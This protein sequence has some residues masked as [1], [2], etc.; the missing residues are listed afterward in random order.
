MTNG[1]GKRIFIIL[2]KFAT[3]EILREQP[4]THDT[5]I[6]FQTRRETTVET[7]ELSYQPVLSL[8]DGDLV[9]VQAV[10]PGTAH[11][12]RHGPISSPGRNR[13]MFH[14]GLTEA[15]NWP[16]AVAIWLAFLG[17]EL[18]NSDF[19]LELRTA[20]RRAD[21]PAER[22]TLILPEATAMPITTDGLIALAG[23]RDLGVGLVLTDFGGAIASLSMLRRL[24]LTALALSPAV[25][26]C[27][28]QDPEDAALVRAAISMAHV[29]GLSVIASGIATD[30]QRGWLAGLGCT[31]GLGPLFGAPMPAAQLGRW[32][33]GD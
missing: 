1:L 25:V 23:L 8:I 30:A 22:L 20:L 3:D 28:P 17:S 32:L 26:G 16:R 15:R 14:R 31:A 2:R 6:D 21:I 13:D 18:N 4:M 7:T 9:A 24:P 12:T 5:I 10:R 29:L 33:R 11:G 19:P 27:L